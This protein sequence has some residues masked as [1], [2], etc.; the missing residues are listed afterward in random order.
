MQEQAIS[1]FVGQMQ[2]QQQQSYQQQMQFYQPR[3]PINC[4]S[5]VM[6]NS[7]STTCY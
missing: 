7:V 6:G 3:S 1:R 4:S 5:N 2:Q